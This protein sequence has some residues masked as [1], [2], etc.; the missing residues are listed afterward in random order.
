MM[1]P[2]L[3][4]AGEADSFLSN[5]KNSNP[6]TDLQRRDL[7][8]ISMVHN[9]KAGLKIAKDGTFELALN[10]E[11]PMLAKATAIG[12]ELART[13]LYKLEKNP[14][15]PFQSRD[16]MDDPLIATIESFCV[17]FSRRWLEKYDGGDVFTRIATATNLITILS[18]ESATTA[19]K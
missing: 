6:I 19:T 8:H 7:H 4:F 11:S 13:F 2:R 10:I 5:T 15:E 18:L 12:K 17:E 1:F 3:P 16:Q 14:P 9:G